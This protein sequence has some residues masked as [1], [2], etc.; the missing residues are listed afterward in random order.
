MPFDPPEDGRVPPQSLEAEQALLGAVLSNAAV[1]DRVCDHV[2]A[3]DFAHPGHGALWAEIAR[4][5]ERGATPTPITLQSFANDCPD[6]E[7]AGGARYLVTLMGSC[8]TTFNTP[9]YARV[10]ADYAHRRRLMGIG[11]ELEINAHSHD[12]ETTAAAIQ[13][14][15]EAALLEVADAGPGRSATLHVSQAIDLALEQMEA[16]HKQRAPTGLLTGY[17]DLDRLLGGIADDEL[18]ILAG[19]PSMGKSAL[20]MSLAWRVAEAGTA[21][22]FYSA[23]MGPDGLAER[24]VSAQAEVGLSDLKQGRCSPERFERVLA[25]RDAFARVPLYIQD[26]AGI[27]VAAIRSRARRMKRR[28]G[29]GLIVVDYLQILSQTRGERS[30]NRTQEITKISAGLK[31]LAKELR[32]PVIALSQLSRAV[33]QREDKRP[34]LSDLRE[35]GAIEQDADKVV[36]V[37]RDEYYLDRSEPSPREGEAADAFRDRLARHSERLGAVRNVMEVIVAKN[38]RGGI[39][40]A[41]LFFH[42]PTQRIEPLCR[43]ETR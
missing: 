33:E 3:D 24:L 2:A 39:G 21:A 7:A 40:T 12:L 29:I 14:Q 37:Y 4:V 20:A 16:A 34:L 18:V 38:R 13:E 26:C 22:D 35:S 43:E 19:R 11:R 28:H 5:S 10:I 6:L 41:R 30:E 27:S 1:F 36:F 15:A 8:V 17:P 25:V 42:A 32:V 23:E 9:E 31:A